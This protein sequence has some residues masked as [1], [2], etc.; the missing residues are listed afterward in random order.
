MPVIRI[1]EETMKRLKAWAKPLED[2]AESAFAKAL[3]IAERNRATSGTP[4]AG[5]RPRQRRRARDSLSQERVSSS[6]PGSSIRSGRQGAGGQAAADNEG[7][8]GVTPPS[9]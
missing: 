1:P 6:P 8:H 2:T 4:A 9:R 5:R 7:T 3:D